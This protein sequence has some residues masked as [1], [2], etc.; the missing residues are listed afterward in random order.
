MSINTSEFNPEQLQ[1]IK[2][3][4]GPLLILAGAGSGKTRVLTHRI[5]YLISEKSVNPYNIMAITF[6]NK[7]A[8]EMRERV[9]RI[10]GSGSEYVWVSTF[11]STCVRILRKFI[12]SLGYSRDFN[13][14][15]TADT[16]SLISDILKSLNID[17][18]KYKEREFMNQIS[19]A[20]NELITPEAFHD[21]NI[22]DPYKRNTIIVYNEYQKRLKANNALDFDDLL[23][24]TVEL[25]NTDKDALEYYRMRFRYIMIDEYQDTNTAQFMLIN[26]L[27]QYTGNDGRILHNLCVVGDDDQS[28]YKFRG[29]NIKNILNFEKYYPETEVIKL[30]QNYRSTAD[31]LNCANAVICKNTGRKDKKLWTSRKGGDS[32]RLIEYDDGRS[33]AYG[34]ASEIARNVKDG[35]ASYND[36]AILYRTNAQSR[37]FEEAL[38]KLDIPYRLVGSVNFYQRKEI[39]DIIAYLRVISNGHDD[40]SLKRIINV[41]KRGIGLTTMDNAERYA[42]DRG[43]SLYDAVSRA[44]EIDHINSAAKVKLKSFVSLMAKYKLM[45][46]SPDF[47]IYDMTLDLIDTIDYYTYLDEGLTKDEYDDKNN[48]VRELLDKIKSYEDSLTDTPDATPSLS[49]FLSDIALMSDLDE[50]KTSDDC[51]TLMTMHSAK[52][53]EFNDVYLAGMEDGMCPSYMS[54]NS[55]TPDEDIEEER[56]LC[57]VG[58]T[59]AKNRLAISYAD[60]RL[61]NGDF[62]SNII[63]RFLNAIPRYML[64]IEQ[65]GT[66]NNTISKSISRPFSNPVPRGFNFA[67]SYTSKSAAISPQPGLTSKNFGTPSLSK[68]DFAVGDAVLHAKFG[69]GIVKS[70]VNGGKD[71]EITVDFEGFGE[72]KLLAS[73][74]K[75][76]KA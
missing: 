61:F 30:E 13:I 63:S 68:P 58:I 37:P 46:D 70:I 8:H 18:K 53:L 31:I 73:F 35:N 20:K 50:L 39:K 41:P 51:V 56:R 1:A 55:D 23:M 28:I 75:L 49:G 32:V 2:H 25:F 6:T 26:Q 43:I 64:K 5:A 36:A 69:K 44:D 33:E 24:K 76:I 16:K 29:A 52:G 67:K 57:Y 47:S 66:S 10:V 4:D 19:S 62:R 71:Y 60:T 22:K 40:V 17:S 9:D 48:N 3:V 59:R 38:V 74:A 7:A 15:D 12:E 34:I 72:R 21:L 14:Y 54:I 42:G 65:G 45:A 27:A 11:H